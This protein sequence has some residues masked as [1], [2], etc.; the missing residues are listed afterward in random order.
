MLIPPSAMTIAPT[1]KLALSEARKATTF[2][3]LHRPNQLP[4]R[5][6]LFRSV[7]PVTN[8]LALAMP[9]AMVTVTN[10]KVN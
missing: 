10:T 1:I 5:P 8:P 3:I 6:T 7:L 2:T 4:R 9:T